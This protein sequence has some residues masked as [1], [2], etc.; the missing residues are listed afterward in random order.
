[1]KKI[2]ELSGNEEFPG[3]KKLL[4]IMKLT[5]FFILFSVVCVFASETYSQTQKL[6]LNM[7]NATV[8][9]ALSAI[10]DQ[11]EFKFMYSG[12]VVDVDREV[13][14][15]QENANI[16]DAL[17][18]LFAGT[19]VNYTIKDRI[20]VLSSASLMNSEQTSALQQKTIWGKVTDN[21]STSL[22]GVSIVVKG[23]N[24]GVITY[25]E[26]KYSIANVPDNAILQFSFV[27][28][29][30]QEI[31][32]G[33]QTSINVVLADETIGL[34]EVV[35]VGYGSQSKKKITGSIQNI[36]QKEL[37]DLPTAQ[38]SQKL[39]GKTSGVQIFQNTGKLGG[40]MSIRI[41]GA[42]SINAGNQPL[43][44]VDGFPIVGDISL[45]NPDEIESISILK[46]ASSTSLYGSRAANGVVLIQTKKGK[47]GKTSIQFN[48]YM[49]IQVV[50][51]KGRPDMMNAKDFY[52]YEKEIYEE[53]LAYYGK[54][55][56]GDQAAYDFYHQPYTYG[57]GTNWYDV[58]TRKATVNSYNI[59]ATST[60]EKSSS[61]VVAGYLNQDCA[62]LLP[63]GRA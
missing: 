6:N 19:D 62:G 42:A 15:N 17:K 43:Y 13:A 23:T 54:L 51:Q 60:T 31:N 7:N 10:E 18:S 26:G 25:L 61:S 1:M 50:P 44:V 12:K 8:K 37:M 33:N 3:V 22:P 4:R 5:T 36:N 2:T 29:K 24:I 45:I 16:E 14:I 9:E 47:D 34:E 28:M 39:Q 32:V 27:G 38:F 53:K 58:L 46:D 57:D 30:T 55:S 35:A 52:Q 20:I 41:R 21:T 11:S 40:G 56:A 48:S 49:G 63:V 59:S